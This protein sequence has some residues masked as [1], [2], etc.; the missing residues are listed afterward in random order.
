[1]GMFDRVLKL[2]DRATPSPGL[3]PSF[4]LASP[5]STALATAAFIGVPT[6]E[7][8]VTVESALKVPPVSRAIQLYTAVLSELP[9]RASAEG[10][11]TAWLNRTVGAVSPTLRN[12]SIVHDLI[13]HRHS[14]LAVARDGAGH[15]VNGIHI[16]Y[17][18]WRIEGL[19]I[20]LHSSVI[21]PDRPDQW[22]TPNQDELLYVPSLMPLGLLDM[23][24]DTIRHY[25]S[26]GRTI[27]DRAD[28][29]TPLIALRV[30][31][32]TVYDPDEL[33]QA[34]ADWHKARTSPNGAVAIV[35]AGVVIETPGAERD[36]SSMLLEARNAV[37][38][39][40]AN[41][42]NLNAALLDGNSGTTDTYSNTLQNK[43][44]FLE[45]SVSLPLRALEARLS[46]DDVTPE[47]VTVTFDTSRYDELDDAKGNVGEATAPAQ[48]GVSA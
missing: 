2:Y 31:D 3:S 10:P 19:E 24:A 14:C 11:T 42:L 47:G 40:V 35:P 13:F 21:D 33:A 27:R 1:M 20:Q 32:D 15:V 9:L 30:A 45:L 25:L 7:L 34:Q 48:I 29:P 17:G 12:V 44:E 4:Y 26:L 39:D 6:T 22:F 8:P 46:Q 36:D 37:R 16:P 38:L 41:F 18:K 23:A 28:N 43:N 5:E